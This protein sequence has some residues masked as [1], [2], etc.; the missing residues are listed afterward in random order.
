MDCA[1][2]HPQIFGWLVGLDFEDFFVVLLALCEGVV[3]LKRFGVF[4]AVS[5]LLGSL[6]GVYT[7]VG[8]SVGTL[9]S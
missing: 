9:L 5:K 7:W 4:A 1:G 8:G 2:L 3:I 6:Q